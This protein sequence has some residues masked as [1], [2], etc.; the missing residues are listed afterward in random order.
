MRI[1]F[2]SLRLRIFV[3][4]FIFI[5]L[6][7]FSLS[8]AEEVFNPQAFIGV[9]EGTR[10][11]RSMEVGGLTSKGIEITIF[12]N[13]WILID[14]S[15]NE[16]G[17]FI[18]K[19]KDA[20]L[21]GST[22]LDKPGDQFN[23]FRINNGLLY[24]IYRSRNTEGTFNELKKIS[25]FPQPLTLSSKELNTFKLSDYK[26]LPAEGEFSSL[27]GVWVGKFLPGPLHKLVVEKIESD[28]AQCIYVTVNGEWKHKV[29]I[30]KEGN[31]I[32]LSLKYQQE[33]KDVEVNY[34]YTG[35]TP[36]R[37]YAAWERSD[38]LLSVAVLQKTK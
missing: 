37:L 34:W 5:S 30:K 18:G 19:I 21:F 16:Y 36:D 31:M 11:R 12:P 27:S 25:N 32:C 7:N 17:V 4:I 33:R 13:L 20:D 23:K 3:A 26:I 6:V 9:W 24:G 1:N 15:V 28:T 38:G 29:K 35:D 2:K 14:Y 22:K 10:M 8:L